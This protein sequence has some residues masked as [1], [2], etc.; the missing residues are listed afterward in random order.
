M[1]QLGLSLKNQGDYTSAID[2][3]EKAWYFDNTDPEILYN[4]ATAYQSAGNMDKANELYN[5]L[6]S[7]FPDSEF[8]T[9][10]ERNIANANTVSVPRSEE[11][12]ETNN[13]DNV[14]SD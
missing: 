14:V 2:K 8:A 10:A 6:V 12:E 3:L 13:E 4:L 11:D 5:E 9:M 7:S 1:I